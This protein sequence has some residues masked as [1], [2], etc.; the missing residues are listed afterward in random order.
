M[1]D[2]R[3]IFAGRPWWMNALM[4]FCAWMA[5]IYVPWDLLIKPVERDQEVWFG[6]MFTGW[7]AKIAAV[8]H[9]V[10]YALGAWGFWKMRSWMHPWAALYIAQIAVGMFVWSLL[11]ERSPG[12]WVG[13]ISALPFAAL[14]VLTW[15]AASLFS[16]PSPSP[17]LP[18]QG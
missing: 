3:S 15:R 5:A 18:A 7:S 17:T 6:I 2:W 12:W 4:L 14:A 16:A 13:V 8:P 10:L 1:P 11:D 9:W